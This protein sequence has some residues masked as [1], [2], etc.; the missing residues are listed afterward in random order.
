MANNSRVLQARLLGTRA[1][2]GK[3]EFLL[4]TPLPLVLERVAPAKTGG[5]A[6]EAEGMVRSGGRVRDGEIFDFGAGIRVTVL[7]SGA[8][9]YRRVRLHWEGPGQGLCRHG[10]HSSAALHQTSERRRGQ[11]P[12]PDGLL[13][14]GQDRIRSCANG[15][16]A[17]Y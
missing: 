8:F 9:G 11:K 7:E 16:P 5:L 10:A 17:F 4:L 2:G 12:L 1:T 6:A 14:R 3:V 13:P 15:G